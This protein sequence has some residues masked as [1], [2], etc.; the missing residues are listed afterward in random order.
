MLR[1]FPADSPTHDIK[2]GLFTSTLE[3][4]WLLSREDLAQDI[5]CRVK[6]AAMPETIVQKFSIN[7]QGIEIT[8]NYIC[9]L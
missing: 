4:D 7:L 9:F 6:S 3:L 1:L 2:D 5:E 8:K